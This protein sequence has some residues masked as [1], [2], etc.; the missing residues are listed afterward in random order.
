MRYYPFVAT[1]LAVLATATYGAPVVPVTPDPGFEKNGEKVDHPLL[2][3]VDRAEARFR[4]EFARLYK[5]CKAQGIPMDYPD[6]TKETLDQFIPLTREDVRAGMEQRATHAVADFDRLLNE[7]CEWM[8]FYLKHPTLVPN[9]RRFQTSKMAV[10][11]ISFV[12]NRRDTTGKEDRGPVFFLGYGHFG[13][14]RKDMP[15]WPRY[16][17]NIIQID[18]GPNVT[19]LT[20]EEVSLKAAQEVLATL[21]NAAKHNVMVNIL[22]AP[23]YFPTWAMEKW[24]HLGKGG[25]GFFGYCIDEQ[26]AK[27]VLERFLSIVVPMFKDHP[28]LHSFCLSNEPSFERSQGCD[29]TKVLWPAYL[30]KVH[31]D[32]AT[33]NRRF[34]T[35]Y[36]SFEDVPY[37][38]TNAFDSPQYYDYT[39]F[40]MERLAD[41][42]KWMGDT[43]HKY[44]PNAL[45]HAKY[46]MG[47]IWNRLTMDYGVDP[48][49]F[50]AL[51]INGN[52]CYFTGYPWEGWA[53]FWRVQNKGYDL[54]RSI[55]TAPIFNSE[56]HPTLDN[57]MDY[58]APEHFEACLWEGAVRGQGATTLWVWERTNDVAYPFY[59]NVMDRPGCVEATGRTSLDLNRFAEEVTALQNAK[60]PVAILYSVASSARNGN[61]LTAVDSVY[62]ALLS[63]GVKIDFITERQLQAGK[64]SQYKMIIFPDATH[65]PVGTFEAARNLPASVC[66]LILGDSLSKDPYN[67][68][69]AADGL[70][71][72]RQDAVLLGA[73]ETPK[74]M[75]PVIL[76]NLAKSGGLP[77][78]SVVSAATG[79]PVY[80]VEWL[81][82]QVGGRTVVYVINLTN[83]AARVKLM[84][85]GRELHAVNLLSLGGI[86]PVRRVEPMRPVLAEIRQ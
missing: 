44:A 7:S 83:K 31:G 39:A 30:R 63:C 16:G 57:N 3:E 72:I 6:V 37:A 81:P 36:A 12:A 32:V 60:S 65:V 4:D 8:E 22:L 71:A 69:H 11:G 54:Q 14:V 43:V 47:E 2:A 73:K 74:Q 82:V 20:A 78:V 5:Q 52:D 1:M 77:D 38:G 85:D 45:V 75:W 40:V 66:K 18:V 25:G 67:Q 56:N 26:E 19:L 59:G 79:N 33:L 86:E 70:A 48:E 46:R 50:A 17:I 42:H 80:G 76:E 64:G 58:V 13:Q 35:S 84:A 49:L 51:D 27:V 29:N 53:C 68:P 21:D 34:G 41:W 28:A 61:Y 62:E 9:A 10:D 24:P 23:H 15:R 55:K